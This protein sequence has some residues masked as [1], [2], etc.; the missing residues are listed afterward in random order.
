MYSVLMA[1]ADHQQQNYE[2][3]KSD[4]DAPEGMLSV[5]NLRLV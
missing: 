5:K 3:A 2:R 1:V 4:A